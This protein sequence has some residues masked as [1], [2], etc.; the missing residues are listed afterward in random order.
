MDLQEEALLK[1]TRQLA[2]GSSRFLLLR[3]ITWLQMYVRII[4]KFKV[5]AWLGHSV[6]FSSAQ[7]FV[8]RDHHSNSTRTVIVQH[9]EL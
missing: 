5:S 6:T 8:G 4:T 2:A 7:S 9:F 1:L 3:S